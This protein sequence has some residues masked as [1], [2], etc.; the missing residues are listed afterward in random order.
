MDELTTDT[1]F[2]GRI[3][4]KQYRSGYRF[5]IDSVL[6]AY[7][8]KPR[9]RDVV[10]DLGTGCGI[11]S[12]ILAYRFP[13]ISLYGVEVQPDLAEIAVLNVNENRLGNR[14]T[15]LC[16]DMVSLDKKAI[17]VPV[18]LI[19]CNPP[20]RKID[21][22]RINPNR[23]RAVARHEIQVKLKDIAATARRLLNASGRFITIYPAGRT[24]ELLSQMTEAGLEPKYLRTIHS[25][26]HSEATRVLVEGVRGGRS[27]ITIGPPLIIYQSGGVYT[28]EVEKMFDGVGEMESPATDKIP[29]N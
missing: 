22:G 7:L 23:Q 10:L 15:I 17:P 9:P 27:G 16:Q 2:K 4:I 1:F 8:A 6:L 12:L 25:Y 3:R 14:L 26:R 19:I 28:E 18:D 20:Y 29:C 5:S 24:T 13:E 21:S 11:L